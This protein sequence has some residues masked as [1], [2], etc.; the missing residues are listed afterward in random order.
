MKALASTDDPAPAARLG[1]LQEA[2][3]SRAGGAVRK[4]YPP[5]RRMTGPQ[6]AG[7]LARRRPV[8]PVARAV[9]HRG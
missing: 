8:P 3:F 6:L 7:Y 9:H 5:E 2:S 1:S 4:A